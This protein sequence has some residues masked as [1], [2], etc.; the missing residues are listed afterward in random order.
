MRRNGADAA[1][2]GAAPPG[3]L[4]PVRLVRRALVFAALAILCGAFDLAA[5][6]AVRVVRVGYLSANSLATD[7]WRPAFVDGLREHGYVE[8]QNLAVESRFAEGRFERLPALA[9]DL[10][11][12]RCDVIVAVVTQASVAARDATTSVPIVMIGVADPVAAGLVASLAR[13]GGNVTGTSGAWTQ[14]VGKQLELLKEI[15]PDASRVAVLWNPGNPIYQALQL[16]EAQIA[17]RTLRL[18]LQLVEARTAAELPRA[19]ATIAARRPVLISADPFFA[20]NKQ[21]IAE[22][23]AARRIP[24]VTGVGE[25]ADAGALLAYGPSTPD[26]ARR[27][28]S[29]VDKIVRGARPADLPVEEPTSFEMVV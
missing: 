5:Q 22:L 13:P 16:R 4:S 14:V 6:S 9:A 11:R 28:A 18:E 15:F 29:Y 25:Y 20:A 23:A 27:S 10:V 24:I 19:F 21:R 2:G 26:L 3:R 7:R 12:V 1:R 17:A 8:G